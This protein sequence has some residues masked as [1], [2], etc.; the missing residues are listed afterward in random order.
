MRIVVALLHL[1]QPGLAVHHMP[2]V[3][4]AIHHLADGRAIRLVMSTLD[5]VTG[6]ISTGNRATQRIGVQVGDLGV[7]TCVV[8]ASDQATGQMGVL[9]PQALAAITLE[10]QPAVLRVLRKH[11]SESWG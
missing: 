11:H 7:H 1:H 9:A 5:H 3:A 2:G 6:S 4:R 10:Y 8:P